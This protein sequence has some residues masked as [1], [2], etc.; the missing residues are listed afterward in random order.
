MKYTGF[1][2]NPIK[3]LKRL[4]KIS[5]PIDIANLKR[6]G[7][8]FD[9]KWDNNILLSYVKSP[10]GKIYKWNNDGKLI[11]IKNNPYK[12]EAQRRKF[13]AMAERGEISPEVVEEFDEASKGL[14]LPERANPKPIRQLGTGANVYYE[15]NKI[16]VN[17]LSNGNVILIA[18]PKGDWSDSTSITFE[19]PEEAVKIAKRLNKEYPQGYPYALLIDRVIEGWRSRSNPATYVITDGDTGKITHELKDHAKAK[20]GLAALNRIAGR[21]RYFMMTF[22]SMGR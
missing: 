6:D 12:S 5:S 15:T 7:W 9:S 18:H 8:V 22:D 19:T 14:K 17:D 1:V 4:L 21:K 16:R 11:L 13:H 10:D 3:P 20:R 2:N